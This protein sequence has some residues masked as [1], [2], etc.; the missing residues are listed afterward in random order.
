[1]TNYSYYKWCLNISTITR[2]DGSGFYFHLSV[3]LHDI[4]KTDV[5]RITKFDTE[6]LHKESWK[7]NYFEVKRSRSRVTK[8]CCHGSLQLDYCEC[9][10]LLVDKDSHQANPTTSILQNR[11]HRWRVVAVRP[12][13]RHWSITLK[14]SQRPHDGGVRGTRSGSCLRSELTDSKPRSNQTP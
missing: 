9:W 1:M 4:S 3:F 6:T 7:P 11:H 10:V 13:P 2:A 5:A 12:Q 14:S 8:H